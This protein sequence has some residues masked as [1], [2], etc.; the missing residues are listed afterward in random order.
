MYLRST[1][2]V[3][4]LLAMSVL[5]SPVRAQESEDEEQESGFGHLVAEVSFWIAQPTG[6]GYSPATESDPTN[7][8]GTAV[9]T[10]DIGSQGDQYSRVGYVMPGEMGTFLMSYF[11]SEQDETTLT[12]YNPGNF[13]YGE[14][15]AHPLFA[16]FS[17]DGLA[18]YFDSTYDTRMTDFRLDFVRKA[19]ERPKMSAEWFLGVRRVKHKRSQS[20]EYNALIPALPA[21]LPPLGGP[22]PALDPSPD[23]AVMA[24]NF[25]GRGLEAGMNFK[26][27]L[28]QKRLTLE[29]GFSLGLLR[30]DL[31]AE[32]RSQTRYYVLSIQ[33]VDTLL[34]PPFPELSQT[35]EN[36][37]GSGIQTPLAADTQQR[38]LQVGLSPT[39]LSTSSQVLETSVGLRW[40][41]WKELTFS[42]G[43]RS[44]RYSDVGLDLRPEVNA[45]PSAVRIVNGQ[46]LG[47]NLQNFSE[48]KRSVT[49]EGVYL[50]VGYKY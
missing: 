5:P 29:G 49:Y 21:F 36:P 41:A 22:F 12:G 46:L 2:C 42:L 8:F 37:P 9:L 26:V 11:R 7:V 48:I 30:G 43:F 39:N 1:L 40:H 3:L 4:L 35:R 6:L 32:Y 13:V 28:I 19:F 50:G 15:L 24:S 31:D 23:T 17:Y 44:T 45:V 47:V 14:T 20:V 25:T 38:T 10:P 33:G 16:G 34:F 18:D 27:P